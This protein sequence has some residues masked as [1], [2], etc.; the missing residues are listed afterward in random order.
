[1]KPDIV[2]FGED[3]G[4]TFHRSVAK[5]KDEVRV[6]DWDERGSCCCSC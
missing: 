2:F 5:D 4:E 3:L 1:M 6:L